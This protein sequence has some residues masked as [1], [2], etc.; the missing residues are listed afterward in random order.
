MTEEVESSRTYPG[1]KT[2]YILHEIK[3]RIRNPDALGMAQIGLPEGTDFSVTAAERD[4]THWCWKPLL[5]TVAGIRPGGGS[6]ERSP[7]AKAARAE[8]LE[9]DAKRKL[10][11][12]SAPTPSSP[13]APS[14]RPVDEELRQGCHVLQ[15]LLVGKVTDVSRA[16]NA[17][18]RIR[19][20]RYTCKMF[21][22]DC[23]AAFP[24]L[25]LYLVGGNDSVTNSGRTADDEYQRTMVLSSLSTGSCVLNLM[26]LNLFVSA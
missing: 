23:L 7:R 4:R 2:V 24:E 17:A 20:P 3:C 16:R 12:P 15:E 13:S 25:A 21:F 22:E 14:K 11:A 6:G 19:D 26:V 8:A 10:P 5:E 18:Q 1:L 9:I